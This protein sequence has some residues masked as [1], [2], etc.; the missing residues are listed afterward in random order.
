[1]PLHGSTVVGPE[2]ALVM[3]QEVKTLLLKGAIERVL[4]PSNELQ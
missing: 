4:P 2:Q 3:E 1:L